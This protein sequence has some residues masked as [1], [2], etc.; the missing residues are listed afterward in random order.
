MRGRGDCVCPSLFNISH[1]ISYFWWGRP[2]RQR[3][4]RWGEIGRER[5]NIRKNMCRILRIGWRPQTFLQVKSWVCYN[6]LR[7]FLTRNHGVSLYCAVVGLSGM[8]VDGTSKVGRSWSG[9]TP[10]V[11]I[12]PVSAVRSILAVIP[13]SPSIGISERSSYLLRSYA[14]LN[15]KLSWLKFIKYVSNLYALFDHFIICKYDM[16]SSPICI[17]F[18]IICKSDVTYPTLPAI[19]GAVEEVGTVVENAQPHLCGTVL[20]GCRIQ[21]QSEY[22]YDIT[23]RYVFSQNSSGILNYDVL[24]ED[25][26]WLQFLS[27]LRSCIITPVGFAQNLHWSA[28]CAPRPADPKYR[29]RILRNHRWQRAMSWW[30]TKP[31]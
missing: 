27:E 10:G 7:L 19:E 26:K 21:V 22:V 30:F 15:M 28:R 24:F 25:R 29:P 8:D 18:L 11:Q 2:R 6:W 20:V 14:K 23:A 9:N 4:S 13:R 5:W 31:F 17:F 16:E 3:L 12:A 1:C